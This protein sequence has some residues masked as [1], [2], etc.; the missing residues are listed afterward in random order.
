VPPDL[1]AGVRNVS[2]SYGT[3]G[4]KQ[5]AIPVL[6]DVSLDVRVGELVA[7]VGPSGCGKT[8]LL[9]LLAGLVRREGV[10][11]SLKIRGREVSGPSPEVGFVFQQVAL[12]PWRSVRANVGFSLEVRLHR[13][14]KPEERERVDQMIE[15]VGL[16][17]FADFYPG[18]L[19]GGM[20]QRVG[21]ARA[22][23]TSAELLLMDE[24]FGALDALSRRL[25]QEELL[26]WKRA[27]AFTAILVT[28]DLDEA[29]YLSDRIV[30]LS[31]RPARILDIIPV[32]FARQ[33]AR[34]DVR[35]LPEYAEIVSRMWTLLRPV[36]EGRDIG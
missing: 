21:V 1:I 31:A 35:R 26:G 6:D 28:H 20:Q 17:S 30:V 13:R 14:L 32:P 12:M 22:L 33:H 8:T 3:Q 23:V 29:V 36:A 24:P 25:L 2:F 15:L 9:R 10:R 19:S 18:Q 11:G 27:K 4:R 16:T 7:L 5:P 34:E